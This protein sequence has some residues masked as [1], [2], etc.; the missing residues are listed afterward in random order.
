[1]RPSKLKRHWKTL[2]GEN[3]KRPRRS[4]VGKNLKNFEKY[5]EKQKLDIAKLCK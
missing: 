2:N 1:M 5:Y 4:F 3:F